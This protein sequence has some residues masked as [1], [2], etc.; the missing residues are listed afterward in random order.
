MYHSK[1]LFFLI[2]CLI[3]LLVNQNQLVI[4]KEATLSEVFLKNNT[5]YHVNSNDLFTGILRKNFY[6]GNKKILSQVK[7]GKLNGYTEEYYRDGILKYKYLMKDNKLNGAFLSYDTLGNLSTSTSY[8]DGLEN[9]IRETYW[10]SG[11]KYTTRTV[12]N[13]KPEGL[14]FNYYETGEIHSTVT[15]KSGKEEGIKTFFTLDGKIMEK[16]M[17]VGGEWNGPYESYYEPNEIQVKNGKQILDIGDKVR[18]RTHYK[19]NVE[20]G[21]SEHY[22]KDGRL[23]ERGTLVGGEWNGVY[24]Y[25]YISTETILTKD[26]KEILNIGPNVRIRA[27]ME[28]GAENGLK[29]FYTPDGNLIERGMLKNGVWHGVYEY[30]SL[31]EEDT[32]DQ[33][34]LPIYKTYPFPIIRTYFVDDKETGI[35]EWYNENGKLVEKGHFVDSVCHGEYTWYY[36]TA[37]SDDVSN[38][39]RE[40][41]NC[42]N[43]KTEGFSEKYYTDG[44]LHS[45]VYF[46]N[47]EANGLEEHYDWQGNLIK[48]ANNKNGVWHGKVKFYNDK[49]K[50]VMEETYENGNLILDNENLGMNS[51]FFND[52]K[53][54]LYTQSNYSPYETLERITR[55]VVKIYD[56]KN[57]VIGAGFFISENHIL[58]AKHLTDGKKDIYFKLKNDDLKISG[59]KIKE[60]KDRD[61][62]LYK[63]NRNGQAIN[64]FYI[65]DF[66]IGDPVYA[67]GHPEGNTY[68]I[69][70]GIISSF[71]DNTREFPE[72]KLI[73]TSAELSKGSSGGPLIHNDNIIGIISFKS[74]KKYS[75]GLGFAIHIDEINDFYDPIRIKNN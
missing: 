73:Q 25:Y 68:T 16:G 31:D 56:K 29:E 57:D 74:R 60:D 46:K 52:Y 62:A 4:A 5:I 18:K 65:P 32:Y 72:T 67:L 10:L 30:F 51:L 42:V 20:E 55:S 54:T 11:S 17:I 24:E 71:R 6:S 39:V 63:V 66:F 45:K 75:E 49:G 13:G 34:G 48:E 3:L 35:K 15:Y 50:I 33:N 23:M 36:D 21:I 58:T 69:T 2:T 12:I 28:N 64:R 53:E 9:G 38:T 8:S 27:Y 26:N 41:K 47:N 37:E 19:N 14:G 22:D 44:R 1:K 43:G 7:N 59:Y 61:L 40:R 70:N